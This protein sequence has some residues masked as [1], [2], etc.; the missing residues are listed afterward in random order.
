MSM[1]R[2]A[3]WYFSQSREQWTPRP[4][5]D[6]LSNTWKTDPQDLQ[7]FST[8][9]ADGGRGFMCFML[10]GSDADGGSFA[11]VHVNMSVRDFDFDVR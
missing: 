5:M 11:S 6:W 10:F 2:L 7:V 8:R 1:R 4:R 3:A 9:G